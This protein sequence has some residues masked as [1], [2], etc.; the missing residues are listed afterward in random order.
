MNPPAYITLAEGES[1]WI[2]IAA[3]LLFM[4]IAAIGSAIQKWSEKNKQKE[5]AKPKPKP[6]SEAKGR[7]KIDLQPARS[8]RSA[9]PPAPRQRNASAAQSARVDQELQL[10][11]QRQAQIE[12]ERQR[13]LAA[14]QSRETDTRAIEA[15]LVSVQSPSK[16]RA[17]GQ[18]SSPS[19]IVNLENLPAAKTAMILHEIFSPPKALRK[20]GEIWDS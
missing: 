14:R 5:A 17:I 9:P 1:S 4:V 8:A 16:E 2:E 18:I 7:L 12:S 11:Q 6:Q 15:K 3:F 19:V 20:G 10:R 13:R